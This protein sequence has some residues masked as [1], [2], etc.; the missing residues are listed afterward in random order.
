MHVWLL[1][2]VLLISR[3]ISFTA[4]LNDFDRNNCEILFIFQDAWKKKINKY[5]IKGVK[6]IDNLKFLNLFHHFRILLIYLL[7]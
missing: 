5:R 7:A 4:L 2:N 6:F 3:V 1:V